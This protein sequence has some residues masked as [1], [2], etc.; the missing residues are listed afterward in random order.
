MK[1]I[2]YNEIDENFFQY[3][4]IKEIKTVKKIINDVKK[5]PNWILH[6]IENYSEFQ[7]VVTFVIFDGDKNGI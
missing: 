3:Q 1:V 4:E 2:K 5:T 6:R 7:K